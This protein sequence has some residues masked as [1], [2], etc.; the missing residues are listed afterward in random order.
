[1]NI[2]NTLLSRRLFRVNTQDKNEVKIVA[3][4]LSSAWS[5]NKIQGLY[6]LALIANVTLYFV[7]RASWIILVQ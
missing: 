6:V 5:S 4:I 7:D 2:Q 3:F 1:M